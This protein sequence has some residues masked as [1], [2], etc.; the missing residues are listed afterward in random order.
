MSRE[1][2]TRVHLHGP[3]NR[4]LPDTSVWLY[5]VEERLILAISN[6]ERDKLCSCIVRRHLSKFKMRLLLVDLVTPNFISALRTISTPILLKS[7][8]KTSYTSKCRPY[9]PLEYHP[10]LNQHQTPLAIP[11]SMFT[12]GPRQLRQLDRYLLNVGIEQRFE[13][14]MV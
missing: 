5:G 13:T 8:L 9:L 11:L 3:R 7:V 14:T 1:W 10:H 6:I 12:T 2:A 4:R